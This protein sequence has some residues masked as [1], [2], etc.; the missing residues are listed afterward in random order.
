M[1][2][3]LAASLIASVVA[4]GFAASVHA[5]PISGMFGGDSTLTLT[6]TPGVFT[7]AYTGDGT[8]TTFGAFTVQSDSIIDFSHPPALLIEDG[9][10]TQTFADGM[11]FGTSS[12]VGTT[13]GTGTGTATVDVMFTGGTGLFMDATGEGTI[14]QTIERTGPSTASGSATYTGTLAL[15]PEPGSLALLATAVLVFYR[16]RRRSTGPLSA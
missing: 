16:R 12:G 13:S 14:L 5:G 11:L 4:A 15:V 7:Q 1:I 8:D 6:A 3:S 9:T 2:R 10:F